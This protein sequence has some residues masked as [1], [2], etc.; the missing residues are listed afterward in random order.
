MEGECWD[1]WGQ[2]SAPSS[3]ALW[4]LCCCVLHSLEAAHLSLW[5]SVLR[6][7]MQEQKLPECVE[8]LTGQRA[9]GD[10]NSDIKLTV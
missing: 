8:L 5:K 10:D 2:K 1:G 6:V 3:P 7:S 4:P 9:T